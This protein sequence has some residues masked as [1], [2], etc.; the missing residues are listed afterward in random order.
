M[1]TLRMVDYRPPPPGPEDEWRKLLL[2]RTVGTKF[3]V[4]VTTSVSANVVTFLRCHPAWKNVIA[5]DEFAE[6]I[7]K[8]KPPPWGDLERSR[9][10]EPVE[11][12][13]VDTDRLV[14]WLA[15]EEFVNVG[16]TVAEQ[17][18]R[19][20]A[21]AH[22]I[23]PVR[24]YLLGLK[25]D[26]IPR[27]ETMLSTYFGAENSEYARGI[28]PRWMIS[29]VARILKPGCQADLTLLLE[30]LQGAGKT[31]GFRE[32]VPVPSWYQDNGLNIESKDS[33]SAL[34]SV[35]I[36][37]L[38]ELGSLKRGEMARWKNFLT[39]VRDR[40]RPPYARREREFLR[41]NVFCGTTNEE[42]YLPDR[43]GN[44]RY[45]PVKTTR[46]VDVSQIRAD[47][48]QLWAEAVVLWTKGTAWHI[49]QAELRALCE[50]EQSGRV[51][52]DP[53]ES[54]LE[55]WLENPEKSDGTT[56]DHAEGF[57]IADVILHGL[58]KKS[59]DITKS[60]EMRVADVLKSL[61]YTKIERHSEGGSRVRRYSKPA[62]P[63]Q[64]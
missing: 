20:A 26:E 14:N 4:Q 58:D 32:L 64:P 47:R 59:G 28:A 12:Q 35:W 3:P 44:R 33:L 37:G 18:L 1:T 23:H 27:L 49:D 34:R 61:G 50:G 54:I 57:I 53:W 31:S 13:D 45:L 5:Y 60:D 8:L 48:D 55:N 10:T 19:V 36:Y 51:H 62:Q 22:R 7:V 46:N 24:Q 16:S 9:G 63:G 52:A 2:T 25:W 39:A 11:W 56:Y 29:A 38:D 21:A 41:Q 42:I 40:Y 17:G 6:T 30:G 15:R 43:T